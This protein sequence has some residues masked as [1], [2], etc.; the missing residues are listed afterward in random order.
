V[1]Q[2]T[3]LLRAG[4]RTGYTLLKTVIEGENR[5]LPQ[6]NRKTGLMAFY[7]PQNPRKIEVC[8]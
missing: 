8:V 4:F 6:K 2:E 7:N 3:P 5:R 1:K